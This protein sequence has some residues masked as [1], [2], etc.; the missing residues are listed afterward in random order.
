MGKRRLEEALK[1]RAK[2][3]AASLA[4]EKPS[5]KT[6]EKTIAKVPSKIR[7]E[8]K[9]AAEAREREHSADIDRLRREIQLYRT[10]STA[11]ITAATFAHESS[12][13]PIKVITNSINSIQTRAKKKFGRIYE[14]LLKSPIETVQRAV[15]GLAVL[16]IA[17]LKLLEH[18]KRRT[19]KAE[20]HKIISEVLNTFKPFTLDRNVKVLTEFAPGAPYLR[21]SEAA[22]ESIITNLINNSLTATEI[23]DKDER[24]I[25]IKTEIF[26]DVLQLRVQD[27]GNG[28]VGVPKEDT[29]LPGVTTRANGTGLGLT[30]VRDTVS[31]LGGT[32]AVNETCSLGGAE[33]IIDIPILGK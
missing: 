5:K 26:D 9:K 17:T 19:G 13:N 3:R 31:D 23:S 29:W 24:I 28:I 27:N 8:V 20:I 18:E 15:R 25:K 1:R 11:G 16:G 22:I 7:P 32:V 21:C 30:I 4:A 2:V 10:L 14:S 6:L 33:F 12:G